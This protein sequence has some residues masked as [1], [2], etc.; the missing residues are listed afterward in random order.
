MTVPNILAGLQIIEAKR[1][2]KE[3]PYHFRAEHD[4]IWAGSLDWGFTQKEKDKLEEL[5]WSADEDADGW[6]TSV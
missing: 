1:P 3:S 5:G 4:E 2:S 6:H